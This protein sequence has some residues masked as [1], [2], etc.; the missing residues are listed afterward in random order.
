[1]ATSLSYSSGKG[2]DAVSRNEIRWEK[3]T[4]ER[5]QVVS[6]TQFDYKVKPAVTLQAR[7]R[8]S[9]TYDPDTDLTDARLEERSLGL[10]YRPVRHDRFNSLFKYTGL[11]DQRPVGARGLRVPAPE[12]GSDLERG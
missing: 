2:L 4:Q 11:S 6:F 12:I 5:R 10:A 9:K 1:M 3:N 7:Y 8:Y